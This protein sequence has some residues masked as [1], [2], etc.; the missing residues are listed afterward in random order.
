MAA[1]RFTA[2]IG[3]ALLSDAAQALGE[4]ALSAQVE[5]AEQLLELTTLPMPV[6]GA[7]EDSRAV[8][9]VVTQVNY[10]LALGDSGGA[11]GSEGKGDQNTVYARNPRTGEVAAVSPAAARLAS[12]ALA[13]AAKVR[14]EVPRPATVVQQE[15]PGYSLIE[16]LW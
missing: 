12:L 2:A 10:Q 9:A 4:D 16:V 14:E 13:A 8:L 11:V 3:H 6:G 15:Y 5:V 7:A 1:P